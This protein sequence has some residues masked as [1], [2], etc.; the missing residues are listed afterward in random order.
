MQA[1][2]ERTMRALSAERRRR[3]WALLVA[4][5]LIA[6][7]V[8]WAVVAVRPDLVHGVRDL[9]PAPVLRV[10]DQPIGQEV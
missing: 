10:E 4:L 3:P 6:G 2:F 1:P 5:A 7:W 8:V 9:L